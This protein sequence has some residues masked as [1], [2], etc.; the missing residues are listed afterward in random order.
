MTDIEYSEKSYGAA[1]ALSGVFGTVGIHH[2]YLGNIAHGL[3][4]LGLFI[5]GLT[6][7]FASEL[8]LVSDFNLATNLAL[9]GIL[10]IAIDIIHSVIVMY[11]LIV[12]SARDG[13]GRLVTWNKPK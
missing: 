10:L 2:F 12:G 9:V 13:H 8:G 3:F 11:Q 5:V 4:D 7:I 6:C 1:V